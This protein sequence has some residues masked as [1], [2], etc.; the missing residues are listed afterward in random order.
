[1]FSHIKKLVAGFGLVI[2]FVEVD[3]IP[4]AGLLN[5]YAVN[6]ILTV[7]VVKSFVAIK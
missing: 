1:L 4:P 5:S 7:A 2:L 3:G 6:I